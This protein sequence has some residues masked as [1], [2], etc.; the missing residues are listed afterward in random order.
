MVPTD[1]AH[2]AVIDAN[3]P[4]EI[5][6]DGVESDTTSQLEESR[7]PDPL[8]L[9]AGDAFELSAIKQATSDPFFVA[10]ARVLI[11][12]EDEE[13]IAEECPGT[14]SVRMTSA[15]SVVL[16]VTDIGKVERG[17]GLVAN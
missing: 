7:S 11:F 10:T 2:G 3:P 5:A 9:I 6:S 4:T 17:G 14:S 13:K 1:A 12:T 15:E 16:C 8:T